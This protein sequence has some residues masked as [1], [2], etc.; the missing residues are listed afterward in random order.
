MEK[1]S[2]QGVISQFSILVP[3][4][5]VFLQGMVIYNCF[6]TPRTAVV[7]GGYLLFL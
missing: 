2:K 7:L 3:Y 5:S 6:R 1:L 4:K